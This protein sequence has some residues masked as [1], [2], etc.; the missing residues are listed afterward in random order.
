[1]VFNFGS[2]RK[3]KIGYDEKCRR[4]AGNFDHH[5]DAAVRCGAHRPM[6]HIQGF[7][8]FDRSSSLR[9]AKKMV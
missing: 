3:Q 2:V 1:M 8:K 7:T 6:E 4:I 9:L 5:A